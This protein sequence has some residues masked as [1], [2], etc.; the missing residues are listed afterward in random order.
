MD[1]IVL[2]D[3]EEALSEV[4][5]TGHRSP[6]IRLENGKLKVNIQHTVLAN[7]GNSI[8]VLSLLSFINRTSEGV[9]VIGRGTPSDL[10]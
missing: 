6:S 9:S 4:T 5:V 2:A 8:E 7:T 10:Y 1:T 3:N